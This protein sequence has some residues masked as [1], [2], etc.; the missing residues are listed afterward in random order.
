VSLL[1]ALLGVSAPLNKD[2]L[3]QAPVLSL[4]GAKPQ[5][6]FDAYRDRCAP[7]DTPD[8]PPRVFRDATGG[9]NMFTLHFVNRA[10]RGPDLAHLKIDCTVALNSSL[11]ADPAKYDDRRYL[12][13]TWTSDGSTVSGVL[14]HEYHAD[15]HKRCAV[16]SSLGCWYNSLIAVSS[17]DGGRSF[18]LARSPVVAAAPFRA[19]VEEGRHR[20][21]FN[22]SNIISDG[23]FYYLLAA[24]TGWTGQPYGV[25]LFRTTDPRDST[26]WR[27][28]DGRAFSV[29]YRD[30]YAP[31]F[32]APKPCMIIEPFLFAVGGVVRHRSSGQWVAVWM[33][34]GGPAQFPVSGLYYATSSDLKVWSPPHLLRMQKSLSDD[35]CE[36]T[37]GAYPALIDETATGRNFD[38]AGDQPWLYYA[39]IGMSKC[40][41]G[42]RLLVRERVSLSLSKGKAS[43]R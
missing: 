5:I 21:F 41:T 9:L 10:L 11:D 27:A 25:C 20:G 7:I 15:Q 17:S 32:V 30:P 16:E 43:A 8:L 24:T 6:M 39:S 37:I 28:W 42:N 33:A 19:N 13:A 3:A 34:T 22:P 1:A 38:D 18:S 31:G 4:T 29:Q 14:H 36:G 40:Q 2:A 35:V 12:A 26:L 23:R